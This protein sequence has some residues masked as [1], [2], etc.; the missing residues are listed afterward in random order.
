MVW[1]AR[2]A[3]GAGGDWPRLLEESA[4]LPEPS[5]LWSGRDSITGDGGDDGSAGTVEGVVGVPGSVDCC[6]RG[7]LDPQLDIGIVGLRL[8]RPPSGLEGICEENR[9]GEYRVSGSDRP[10]RSRASLTVILPKPIVCSKE[11]NH[12]LGSQRCFLRGGG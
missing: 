8:P 5:K 4:R 10:S 2:G 11:L 7:G 3:E 9:V 6:R 12:L 1:D